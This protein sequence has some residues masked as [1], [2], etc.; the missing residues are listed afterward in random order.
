METKE[1][2]QNYYESLNAKDDRWKDLYA[3]DA[4][5]ADASL[6]LNAKGKEAVVKSFTGFLQSTKSIKVKQMIA[7]DNA[8]C[9]I[10]EYI[11]ENQ[12]GEKMTQDDAEIWEVRDGKLAKLTIYFDLTAFRQFM[13]G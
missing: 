12:K 11:Y 2:I 4:V 6:T 13:R 9:A 5:F 10:V 7:E 3:D 8:V 1:L